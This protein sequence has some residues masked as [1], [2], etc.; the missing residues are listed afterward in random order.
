MIYFKCLSV[1]CNNWCAVS[2][3]NGAVGLAEI[4]D[5]DIS[6]FLTKI[7]STALIEC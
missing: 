7:N 1:L 3:P 5:C 2:L 6:C 4:C